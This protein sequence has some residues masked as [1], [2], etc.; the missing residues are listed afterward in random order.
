MN[1][2]Y[3]NEKRKLRFM[4]TK[5]T[6]NFIVVSIEDLICPPKCSYI[7]FNCWLYLNIVS[8]RNV[9]NFGKGSPVKNV[10][11]HALSSQNQSF[12]KNRKKDL[13]LEKMILMISK[14]NSI[15]SNLRKFSQRSYFSARSWEMRLMRQCNSG[16]LF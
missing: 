4:F 12:W 3:S 9:T 14:K 16:T 5:T 11:W 2:W 7:V 10:F 13:E 15:H 6:P 1:F 8:I